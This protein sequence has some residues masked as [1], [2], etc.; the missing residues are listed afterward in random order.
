M[1]IRGDTLDITLFGKTFEMI[2]KF[3]VRRRHYYEIIGGH[4]HAP[5]GACTDEGVQDVDASDT[6][7]EITKSE[8]LKRLR[9]G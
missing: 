5:V 1:N 7:Q 9:D 4:I 3:S 2:I 8:Y 6:L